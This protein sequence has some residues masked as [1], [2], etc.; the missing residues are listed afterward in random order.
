MKYTEEVL[1]KEWGFSKTPKL[2]YI[3]QIFNILDGTGSIISNKV[4]EIDKDLYYKQILPIEQINLIKP[5][6]K[7]K[8]KK[9]NNI[10]L[11][12]HKTHI[13]QKEEKPK[14]FGVYGI[15]ENDEL[16]YIGY[17]MR[18]FSVRWREHSEAIIKQDKSQE[19]YRKINPNSK[20]EFGILIDVTKMKVD[21]QLKAQDIECMELALI[22]LYWPKYNVQGTKIPYKFSNDKFKK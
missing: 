13:P 18:D 22:H 17:T 3:V 5:F 19:I 16:V 14:H 10:R 8:N 6:Y 2:K 11:I 4:L 15:Y 21:K 7:Y 9:F 1:I 20:I 12:E